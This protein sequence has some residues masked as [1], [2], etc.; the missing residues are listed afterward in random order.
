VLPAKSAAFLAVSLAITHVVSAQIFFNSVNLWMPLATPLLVELPLAL[1]IGLLSQ[2]GLARQ[3]QGRMQ[4]ALGHYVPPHVAKGLA[5]PSVDLISMREPVYAA[6]LAA[7]AEN[8]T[9]LAEGMTPEAAASY[10]N[11]Y[12]HALAEAMSRHQADVMK[13]HVN[14]AM[15]AWTANGP[16]PAVRARA[17]L[18]ALAAVEAI[19]AFNLRCP[20]LCLEVGVG[21]H[22]GSALLGHVGGGGH[23][24]FE[25]VGD[26]A[27][28]AVRIEELNK[29][30]GTHVLA[31]EA[32]VADLDDFLLRPLGAFLLKGKKNATA[33][34][35]IMAAKEK[36]SLAQ[37]ALC[38]RFAKALAAFQEHNWQQAAEQFEAILASHSDDGPSRFY[39]NNCRSR[40]KSDFLDS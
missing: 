27:S 4:R 16:D 39:L 36:A 23:F 1:L 2:Y 29:Q 31:S 25:I 10:L 21:L 13:F 19:D 32:A 12:F 6:C 15:Y 37:M 18:A 8:F 11:S 40:R 7:D 22:A 26:I 38:G 24:D 33:V 17:C 5:D 9:C 28:T 14:D 30:F 35:E 34:V 20:P 3:Q